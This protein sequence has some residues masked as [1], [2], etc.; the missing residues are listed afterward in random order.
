M[1]VKKIVFII[2]ISIV[3]ILLLGLWYYYPQ[4][5]VM[6]GYAARTACS[7]YFE[8]GRTE[9][10]IDNEDLGDDIFSMSHVEIDSVKQQVSSTVLG[11]AQKTAVYRKGMGCILLKDA[12][13]QSFSFTPA[14]DTIRRDE[15]WKNAK[16]VSLTENEKAIITQLAFDKGLQCNHK[17]TRALLILRNDSLLYE[18]YAQGTDRHTPLLGWSM[19]KSVLSTLYGLLVQ[20]GKTSLD[21]HPFQKNTNQAYRQTS[22]KDLLQMRAGLQWE[23]K[24]DQYCSATQML[25]DS[26]DAYGM[27]AALPFEKREWEYSSGTSNLLSGL[28]KKKFDSTQAYLNYPY[29]A[30]FQ[31]LDLEH[32]WIETDEKGTM[33]ASS[34]M[35]ATARDWLKLGMLYLHNGK[36]QGQALLSESWVDFVQEEAPGSEG[37]Y[38]GHFWLNKN[39][40]SYKD[41]PFDMYTMDGYQGQLV[42]ILPTQNMVVVRLGL[43]DIDFNELLKTIVHA[44]E[45]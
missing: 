23:E 14:P 22:V 8:V 11:I 35:Y 18:Q 31:P 1:K 7:C 40:A 3:F 33:I 41:V 12:D 32:A 44:V 37:R 5:K 13:D 45:Q 16:S 28:M 10:D 43:A 21:E 36:W 2:A 27:V 4:L 6:N 9:A 26:D 15:P 24:Y 17:K 34:Y 29:L 38:G 39:G 19:T 25:F 20:Q 42:A 30:L